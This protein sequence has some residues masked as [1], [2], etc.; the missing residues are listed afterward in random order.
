MTQEPRTPGERAE[1]LLLEV[2]GP[3][4][5]HTLRTL[6][7]VDLPSRLYPGR[8][9]RLDS[10]GNLCYRDPGDAGFDVSL[11]VQPQESVPRDDQ[12]A[13]R[14]LLATADEERLLS[15]ANPVTFGFTSLGR[16]L[17]HDFAQRYPTWV[18]AILTPLVILFF[19]GAA[20]AELCVMLGLTGWSPVTA[21]VVF[22]L[23]LVPAMI[24]AVLIGAAFSDLI[25]AHRVR[26]AR[27]LLTQAQ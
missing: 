10:L 20:L 11:C 21:I 7:F 3:E 23:L 8:V 9:Y 24:G 4:R 6:G 16:A 12:I 1:Q 25:R 15:T 18:A 14:Y 19:I 22:I 13:M 17:Y 27:R 5:F 26:R 2:M